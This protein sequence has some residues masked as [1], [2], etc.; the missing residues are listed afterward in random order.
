MEDEVLY[1]KEAGLVLHLY[2]QLLLLRE[3][4]EGLALRYDI[5]DQLAVNACV[6]YVEKSDIEEGIA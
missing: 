6:L 4:E 3:V 2:I 1:T 5:L